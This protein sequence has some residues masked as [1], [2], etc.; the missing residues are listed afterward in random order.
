MELQV[1]N[2]NNTPEYNNLIKEK[3]NNLV[4]EKNFTGT[5]LLNTKKTN[6]DIL[7]KYV[8]D[9]SKIHTKSLNLTDNNYF[10]EFW[11]KNKF[12]T[13]CLHVDCD[14]HEKMEKSIYNYPL[15]SC[16][17]YFNKTNTPTVVSNVDMDKFIYKE[18]HTDNNFYFSFPNI[19]KHI[20]F[21]PSFFHGTAI[22]TDNYD[23]TEERIIIAFNIW[24]TQPI[25]IQYY[26]N[27]N[28]QSDYKENNIF[29]INKNTDDI[30]NIP[31]SEQELNFDTMEDILYN[32]NSN[33]FKKFNKW[34][35]NSLTCRIIADKNIDLNMKNDKLI[36]KYGT[37]I[38]DINY[39]KEN[40]IKYNRFF[41]RFIYNR[42]YNSDICNWI[43]YESEKYASNN[44]G[45][46]TKRHINYPTTDIPVHLIN[47][48]ST[49]IF[50]SSINICNFIKESYQIPNEM[51]L[52]IQ[53]LF[54]VKYEHDKQNFLEPHKDGSFIS[55]NIL[56]T[57]PSDFEGGGTEFEDGLITKNMQGDLFIHS[58][59]ITHSGIPITKGKRYLLVGFI[60]LKLII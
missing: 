21:N 36:N 52:D 58:S 46:T 18:F 3:I 44:G 57:N 56:L 2:T 16:V 20:T 8:Y 4:I 43:I 24:K 32:N 11:F 25:N 37:I 54:I 19:N 47:S 60:N 55:F 29:L 6:F 53:D 39:I 31:I 34:I 9:L 49:F 13:P 15:L 26:D 10:V 45:W 17:S 50:Q 35:D 38:N 48:I 28:Y 22:L 59:L 40:T 30:K 33:A 7:E 12:E 51:G 27:Y 14:E 42:F 5:R 23:L 41:Q 1:W